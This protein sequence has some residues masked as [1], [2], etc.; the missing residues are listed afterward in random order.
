MASFTSDFLL[1]L[2]I[3]LCAITF[4]SFLVSYV[5][6]KFKMPE[7]E[8]NAVALKLPQFWEK[9]PSHWFLHI[10]SQFATRS[11]TRSQTKYDYVIASLSQEAIASIYDVMN[12]ISSSQGTDDA[13]DDPYEHIKKFLIERHTLSESARIET[14]LSGL[15]LG[16]KKPSEFFRSLKTLAGTSDAV[17]DKLI[18]NL[19]MRRLP[20]MV[21]AT[22]KAIPK[23]EIPDQLSMA[24]NVYEI[25]RQ[26]SISQ[27]SINVL[28]HSRSEQTTLNDVIAHNKRLEREISELKGRMSRLTN[29]SGVKSNRFRSRTR[30]NQ[31]YRSNSNSRSDHLRNSNQSNLCWYH[32]KYGDNATKCRK[33]CS[34]KNSPN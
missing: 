15:E 4:I 19:W 7:S 30:N 28:S 22:L 5:C 34:F 17:N 20:T 3:L 33:P 25:Y 6:L 16:D 13:I 8:L 31:G 12:E 26:Q 18:L 27:P 9:M 24:D 1:C 21:Q 10:E 2:G 14:L 23:A 29:N 11:I 32:A